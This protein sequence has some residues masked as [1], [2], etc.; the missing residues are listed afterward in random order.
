MLVTVNVTLVVVLLKPVLVTVHTP[1]EFVVQLAVPVPP[2]VHFTLT[3]TPE[4]GASL[5]L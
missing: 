2:F 5:A 4:S 3:F 1:L